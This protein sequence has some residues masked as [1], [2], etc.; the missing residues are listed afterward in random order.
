VLGAI[1]FSKRKT[2]GI[3]G[4]EAGSAPASAGG[5]VAVGVEA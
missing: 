3:D 2:A 1:A 4:A 5:P